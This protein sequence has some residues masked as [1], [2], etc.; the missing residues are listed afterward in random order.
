MQAVGGSRH[1]HRLG[2]R[3][4]GSC[5]FCHARVCVCV[6]CV[7]ARVCVCVCVGGEVNFAVLTSQT[8]SPRTDLPRSFPLQQDPLLG[9][10]RRRLGSERGLDGGRGTADTALPSGKKRHCQGIE[11]NGL[12][13]RA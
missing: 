6:G 11:R 4:K 3:S 10:R 5:A 12:S 9:R 13:L 2:K 8:W 7:C 1:K